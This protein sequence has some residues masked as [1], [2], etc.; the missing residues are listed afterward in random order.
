M[1]QPAPLVTYPPSLD[2]EIGRWLVHRFGPEYKECAHSLFVFPFAIK[3]FDS[4]LPGAPTLALP[5]RVFSGA[6]AISDYF[7]TVVPS[8]QRLVPTDAEG[9]AAVIAA[10]D[11]YSVKLGNVVRSWAYFNFLQSRAAM[12]PVFLHAIPWYEKPLVVLTYSLLRNFLITNL[13]LTQDVADISLNRIKKIFAK[14]EATLADGRPYLLGQQ[15]TLCDLLFAVNAAPM[16]LP[17]EHQGALPAFEN[18]PPQAQ[19]VITELRASP[20]GQYVLRIYR[21]Q[22]LL[23]PG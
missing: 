22:R 2:C 7:E 5:D 10:W 12:L 20:V 11:E 17:A 16:L 1:T 18:V 13:E 3:H 19:Q 15:F 9:Q 21:E 6:R 8:A 4:P 14:A 23:R